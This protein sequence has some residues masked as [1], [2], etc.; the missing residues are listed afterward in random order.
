M[1]Y[2]PCCSLLLQHGRILGESG[3]KIKKLIYMT[4]LFFVFFSII[5]TT[6]NSFAVGRTVD[7]AVNGNAVVFPDAKPFVDENNRT[8]APARYIAEALGAEVSWDNPS[9]TATVVKGSLTI[10][11]IIGDIY[12]RIN[13]S[14]TKM[15]TMA[16]SKNGRTFIPVK[17]L[18]EALGAY[19]SY[20][21]VL[22]R[23][24]ISLA[25]PNTPGGAIDYTSRIS[26]GENYCM[27]ILDDNTLWGWG[28]DNGVHL[29]LRF[30]DRKFINKPAKILDNA[31]AVFAGWGTTLVIKNDK[32]LWGWGDN[33][34][35]TGEERLTYSLKPEKLLNNVISAACG[36]W[37][38]FAVKTDGSLWGWGN[39]SDTILNDNL[40]F[41]DKKIGSYNRPIVAP[42]KLLDG[43]RKVSA[44]D[45]SW[46]ALKKDGTLLYYGQYLGDQ[47][48]VQK[49]TTGVNI[50]ILSTGV[51]DMA[52]VD[53]TVYFIKS[54]DSLW[55]VGNSA[56]K[57][58]DN[59]DEY[60]PVRVMD[61]IGFVTVSRS[62]P[63]LALKK[64]GTLMVWGKGWNGSI[65]DMLFGKQAGGITDITK[66]PKYKPTVLMNDVRTVSAGPFQ[67]LIEKKDGTVLTWGYNEHGGVG[68]GSESSDL[69]N[70]KMVT[71]DFSTLEDQLFTA[72][73]QES[74]LL[75]EWVDDKEVQGDI[76]EYDAGF[77]ANWSGYWDNMIDG[78]SY[79]VQSGNS[80]YGY[81]LYGGLATIGTV[82][83]N[84]LQG[85][86]RNGIFELTMLPDGK[87]YTG[88]IYANSASE[89][90]DWS[91]VKTSPLN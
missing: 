87:S 70:S 20:N 65:I 13:A 18:A 17:Y 53:D 6:N 16:I 12:I 79:M 78:V 11:I 48:H 69:L 36:K 19:V 45:N 44:Y 46:C 91:G 73:G 31:D 55:G 68:D 10:K 28:F 76:P 43:V 34:P 75:S 5:N 67:Y 89:P 61:G 50:S 33:M 72:D 54:D 86:F 9:Q 15:D 64:D 52:M 14:Q 4:V 88:L 8:L 62:L 38:V 23:V 32:T 59:A 3:M 29:G 66:I 49:L 30:S 83:G 27:A 37:F 84:K 82:K 80:V 85:S 41:T 71:L 1:D 81:T 35:G 57:D 51:R 2:L 25:D 7:V 56:A 63:T 40:V 60:T 42:V 21:N 26:A 39:N 74:K 90:G 47:E 24:E 77:K 58:I 22:Q